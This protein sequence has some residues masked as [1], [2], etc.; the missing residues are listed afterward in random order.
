MPHHIMKLRFSLIVMFIVTFGCSDNPVG[1]DSEPLVFPLQMG[2]SWNYT[3]AYFEFNFDPRYWQGSLDTIWSDLSIEVLGSKTL[4]DSIE[5]F[6]IYERWTLPYARLVSAAEGD[7][8]ES[9][10]Y[11]SN[12]VDGLYLHGYATTLPVLFKGSTRG[13]GSAVPTRFPIGSF[14]PSTPFTTDSVKFFLPPRRSPQISC[15]DRCRLDL[16]R[17]PSSNCQK[18][19]HNCE[20]TSPGR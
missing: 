9:Y 11:L 13:E 6:E 5:T 20:S 18:N 7:F 16:F 8:A 17:L 19:N 2:S 12:A 4:L 14:S 15:C 1:S 10:V 3:S